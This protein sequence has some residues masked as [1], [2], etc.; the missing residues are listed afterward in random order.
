M[1]HILLYM[2]K[3]CLLEF[4]INLPRLLR[5][6]QSVCLKSYMGHQRD[7]TTIFGPEGVGNIKQILLLQSFCCYG[8]AP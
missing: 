2:Q 4:S 3:L 6:L 1:E 8:S 7:H 5:S